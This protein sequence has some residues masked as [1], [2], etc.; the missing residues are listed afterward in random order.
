MINY[1]VQSPEVVGWVVG[2]GWVDFRGRY[3]MFHR[4]KC[5]RPTSGIT[6]GRSERSCSLLTS[7]LSAGAGAAGQLG[8]SGAR[9]GQLTQQGLYVLI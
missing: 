3:R 1:E 7:D 2:A 4:G 6:L 8:G 5:P 9:G